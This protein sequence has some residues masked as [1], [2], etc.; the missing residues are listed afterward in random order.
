M[1]RL[2]YFIL[3]IC[4][5]ACPTPFCG[6]IRRRPHLPLANVSFS[7]GVGVDRP[8]PPPPSPRFYTNTNGPSPAFMGKWKCGRGGASIL[9]YYGTFVRFP[10]LG[11]PKITGESSKA[12]L[13][14]LCLIIII[15]IITYI[16]LRISFYCTASK[17][18][19]SVNNQQC[20]VGE[21]V[22]QHLRMR[23]A[24][25]VSIRP[26]IH[27]SIHPVAGRRTHRIADRAKK[28]DEEEEGVMMIDSA[29]FPPD[30]GRG[31]APSPLSVSDPDWVGRAL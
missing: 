17:A 10:N 12:I 30:S 20:C 26:S 13:C 2:C 15:I 21:G 7:A 31:G 29:L 27:P 28:E 19:S 23:G 18:A 14:C 9:C 24:S 22:H 11:G 4:V 3:L 25:S 16:Q 8:P 1:R 6:V 5:G